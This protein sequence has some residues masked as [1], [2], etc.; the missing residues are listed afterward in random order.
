MDGFLKIGNFRFFLLKFRADP[1][2]LCSLI[3]L[4]RYV[5][6]KLLWSRYLLQKI[7]IIYLYINYE[8]K[9]Y[10]F[11][12]KG[13]IKKFSKS[14]YVCSWCC[15]CCTAVYWFVW[16]LFLYCIELVSDCLH[17][18]VELYSFRRQ[19][20]PSTPDFPE[21]GWRN[22]TTQELFFF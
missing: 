7:Y 18:E 12:S 19:E 22:R 16:F 14:F 13:T 2:W 6:V 3:Y 9:L 10:L 11:W 1:V 8:K 4:D 21:H 15:S 17:I 20:F 5:S